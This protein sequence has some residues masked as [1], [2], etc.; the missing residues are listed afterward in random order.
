MPADT[1]R[2]QLTSGT[3]SGA[4]SDAGPGRGAERGPVWPVTALVVLM[5]WCLLAWTVF[6][7]L[8]GSA[9]FFGDIPSRARYVESGMV[10]LTAL[11][12]I[13]LLLV[14]GGLA[15]SRWGL[16]LL[17]APALLLVPLGLSLLTNAGDPSDPDHGRPVRFA[18]AFQDLTRLNWLA[19]VAL[20]VALGL[21]LWRRRRQ[22]GIRAKA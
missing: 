14:L 15:G 18:D 19:A 22:T 21:V 9:P 4:G 13:A 5:G 7:A 16:G 1:D 6:A 11:L 8:M 10:M 12:P 17:A 2:T 20:L 3:I